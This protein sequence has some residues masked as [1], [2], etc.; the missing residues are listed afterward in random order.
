ML[1]VDA[2][3]ALK[4]LIP[5]DLSGAAD[6]LLAA[7]HEFLAPDLLILETANALW[8][9][10]CLGEIGDGDADEALCDL[11]DGPVAF[12]PSG[13]LAARAITIARSLDHPVYDCIYLALAESEG[14]SVIT[15]D[16]RF[17]DRTRGGPWAARVLWLGH[18]P[19]E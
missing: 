8:K 18:P 13:P 5:E 10:R 16:R 2:S 12:K 14:G 19:T 9:K 17:L 7:D 4:W 6:Q 15:A 1:V 3:V 11:V